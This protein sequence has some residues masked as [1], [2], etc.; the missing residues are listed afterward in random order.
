MTTKNTKAR[1]HPSRELLK[2]LARVLEP[3][4]FV[5]SGKALRRCAEPGVTHVF[6]LVHSAGVFGLAVGVCFREVVEMAQAAGPDWYAFVGDNKFDAPPTIGVCQLMA[7]IGELGPRRRA[8]Q[9]TRDQLSEPE[10]IDEVARIA[11]D[12]GLRALAAAGSRAG[13]LDQELLRRGED[14]QGSAGLF[15]WAR[16]PTLAIVACEVGRR[17]EAAAWLAEEI[18]DVQ[19]AKPLYAA[20]LRRVGCMLGLT[21][22]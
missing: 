2:G 19:A 7:D 11:E 17:D 8:V 9:W 6:E 10:V 12:Q 20:H 18:A 21:L 13:L 16:I 15:F 14:G 5:R 1:S 3:A 4:G 22:L